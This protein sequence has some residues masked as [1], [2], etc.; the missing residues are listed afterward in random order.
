MP[1]A[2]LRQRATAAATG[3]TGNGAA[4]PCSSGR[5]RA[6]QPAR[7]SRHDSSREVETMSRPQHGRQCPLLRLA[8]QFFPGEGPDVAPLGKTQRRRFRLALGF[9]HCPRAVL[10][11]DPGLVQGHLQSTT[12][13]LSGV[14]FFRCDFGQAARCQI[15][16]MLSAAARD[17]FSTAFDMSELD[18]P[19][20]A[21]RLTDVVLS[22]FHRAMVVCMPTSGALK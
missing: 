6:T 4:A 14:R 5:S 8:V 19:R 11:A 9:V 16:A 22:D 12:L 21:R 2:R 18:H 17:S 10:L 3:R 20:Y 7:R 13:L 1:R 15:S